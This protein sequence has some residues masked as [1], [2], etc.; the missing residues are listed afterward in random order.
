MPSPLSEQNDQSISADI[1]ADYGQIHFAVTVE[2]GSHHGSA[3]EIADHRALV[4]GWA[5]LRRGEA[6]VSISQKDCG[7]VGR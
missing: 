6:S 3:N 2:V 7:G 1:V 5:G 4:I